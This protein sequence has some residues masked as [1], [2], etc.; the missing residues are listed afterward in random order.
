L[1]AL[2]CSVLV[3]ATEPHSCLLF[4]YSGSLF[5]IAAIS[6]VSFAVGLRLLRP[7]R[8]DVFTLSL[9]FLVG[10]G[11][12]ALLFFLTGLAHALYSGIIAA[13]LLLL[14][15]FNRRQLHEFFASAGR[16]VFALSSVSPALRIIAGTTGIYLVI[17]LL[18]S[19]GP[20]TSW[21]AL[22]SHWPIAKFFA[23]HHGVPFPFFNG[24][25]G[26]PQLMRMHFSIFCLFGF[27]AQASHAVW[28][29]V[30]ALFGLAFG[31]MRRLSF[32]TTALALTF[33]ALCVLVVQPQLTLQPTLDVPPVIF[34][35]G[36]LVAAMVPDLRP[37]G[38][39]LEPDDRLPVTGNFFVMSGLLAGYALGTKWHA[40]IL[41]PVIMVCYILFWRAGLPLHSRARKLA[42]WIGG[43]FLPVAVFAFYDLVHTGTPFWHPMVPVF[44]D[45]GFW[46]P[47]L[48]NLQLI[49]EN[50]DIYRSRLCPTLSHDVMGSLRWTFRNH[51][52]ILPALFFIPFSL[53]DIRGRRGKIILIL[54]GGGLFCFFAPALILYPHYRHTMLGVAILVLLV[55]FGWDS[56]SRS[57]YRWLTAG[58]PLLVF[59]GLASKFA[60]GRH[61]QVFDLYIPAVR[62]VTC[63]PYFSDTYLTQYG[64]PATRWANTHL[65]GD[66]FVVADQRCLGNLDRD[67]M[68]IFPATQFVV[69]LTPA[70]PADSLYRELAGIGAT[71]IWVDKNR[72]WDSPDDF[73]S[74][75]SCMV[76]WE[77]LINRQDLLETIYDDSLTSI[78]SLRRQ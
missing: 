68:T 46:S 28:V 23:R 47:V 29:M 71:H 74:L 25:G 64:I 44:W 45:P 56:L 30:P 12:L 5:L 76:P 14:G 75:I 8:S 37:R 24:N 67:W 21:D 33:G 15:V 55:P 31:M 78:L 52:L 62:S 63:G 11:L 10:Y 72:R 57:K 58:L 35:L 3:S 36:A 66:A 7:E 9:A 16:L 1:P 69:E 18:I 49:R 42:L 73:P 13:E 4:R 77:R 59:V 41:L 32:S 27:A 54:L 40:V 43:M 70:I 6:L 19:M 22:E 20:V 61:P 34:G 39:G 60:V 53:G 65:P 51:A 2:L 26:T 50:V 48:M 38:G 17:L